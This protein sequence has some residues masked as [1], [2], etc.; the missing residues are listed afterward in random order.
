VNDQPVFMNLSQEKR[1]AILKRLEE[2]RGPIGACREC[3]KGPISLQPGIPSLPLLDDTDV[4]FQEQML[5]LAAL[6]C[7][8]CG[9]TQFFSMAAIG[10]LK[11][12]IVAID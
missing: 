1:Q 9:Y 6:C 10:L 5:P 8:H 11:D 2:R 7:G 3:G 4:I 12:G